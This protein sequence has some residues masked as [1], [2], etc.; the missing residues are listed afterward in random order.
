MP[1]KCFH[2][3]SAETSRPTC[4]HL[5]LDISLHQLKPWHRLRWVWIPWKQILEPCGCRSVELKEKLNDG[6][7]CRATVGG[8]HSDSV[9]GV[10]TQIS[11]DV[12]CLSV[13]PFWIRTFVATV[14]NKDFFCTLTHEMD[15]HPL[16][17]DLMDDSG[18]EA[19]G[20]VLSCSSVPPSFCR[21]L[22]LSSKTHPLTLQ[23]EN[24]FFFTPSQ[25]SLN[26]NRWLGR[27]VFT[28]GS[29]GFTWSQLTC[30]HSCFL[31][32]FC[33]WPWITKPFTF[34]GWAV[35][36]TCSGA[37]FSRQTTLKSDA[38]TLLKLWHSPVSA[39][40]RHGFVLTTVS[41]EWCQRIFL[42]RSSVGFK[43]S[44]MFSAISEV[45]ST[46][47]DGSTSKN[48]GFSVKKCKNLYF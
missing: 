21:S 46:C 20:V 5:R 32:G 23:S 7:S 2:F 30:A 37:I 27:L 19:C 36:G 40:L 8:F 39:V 41:P 25:E 12:N 38:G 11:Q 34:F 28:A 47:M 9:F 45:L 13:G 10:D 35:P 42:N 43:W 22:A 14:L 18:A 3:A 17:L 1:L 44:M 16:V 26:T 6:R 31:S 33:C 4:R 48:F 29:P 15:T 24:C